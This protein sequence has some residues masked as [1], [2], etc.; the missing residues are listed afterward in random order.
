[1]NAARFEDGLTVLTKYLCLSFPA[2]ELHL[3]E[4]HSSLQKGEVAIRL[5]IKFSF[6]DVEYFGVT[7]AIVVLNE[8]MKA[9]LETDQAA[10]RAEITLSPTRSW[11]AIE[12][13]IGFAV[14]FE[15]AENQIVFPAALLDKP[16]PGADPINHARLLGLCEQFAAETA[17]EA[18]PVTQV[19]AIL[20]A[21]PSL[22]VSLSDVAAELGYSE[23]GLRRQL[24]RSGTSYRKLVGRVLEQRARTLLTGSTQPIKAIAGV[25]GFESS[26]NFAR[27]FKRWTGLSPKAF[28]DQARIQA[29]ACRK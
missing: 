23:R 24:D 1:M 19:M 7:S 15:A 8:L 29:G 17:F 20:E 14:R 22:S 9:M 3:L 13:K 18:T 4:D 12:E 16:L 2:F 28:R 27:S 6:E 5:R 10:T 21:K 11:P 26:S 25:L